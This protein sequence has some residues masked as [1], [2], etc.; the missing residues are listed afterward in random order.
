MTV[1]R[2]KSAELQELKSKLP[3]PQ[4]SKIID[5]RMLIPRNRELEEAKAK[6]I[7]LAR[8]IEAENA[9]IRNE[10]I[11]RCVETLRALPQRAKYRVVEQRKFYRTDGTS[12]LIYGVSSNIKA[13]IEYRALLLAA[14]DVVRS[15]ST[16]TDNEE[17][18][19]V[20]EEWSKRITEFD[21]ARETIIEM[22]PS[23]RREA[24][25]AAQAGG[26]AEPAWMGFG[27]IVGAGGRLDS[28]SA[29]KKFFSDVDAALAKA[30]KALKEK[31]T[32]SRDPALSDALWLG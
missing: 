13:I 21:I 15:E 10:F 30:D 9:P 20:V 8:Q 12:G 25:E 23:E 4:P 19:K 32:P 22:T 11:G 17:F 24:E 6:V 16:K 29:E 1:K 7:E 14:M 2:T 27:Q 18:K 28:I 3:K 5:S 31:H 26:V